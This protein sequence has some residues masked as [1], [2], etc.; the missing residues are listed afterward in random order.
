MA[1]WQYHRMCGQVACLEWATEVIAARRDEPLH[2]ALCDMMTPARIAAFE[3][4]LVNVEADPV[5]RKIA[6]RSF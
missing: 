4:G 3:A 6:T 5:L 1:S 2:R